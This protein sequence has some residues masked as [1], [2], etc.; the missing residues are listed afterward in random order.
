MQIQSGFEP[1]T[2]IAHV[3]NKKNLGFKWIWTPDLWTWVQNTTSRLS[4]LCLKKN[5]QIFNLSIN[6][7]RCIVGFFSAFWF[8]IIHFLPILTKFRHFPPFFT[9]IGPI[10]TIFGNFSFYITW[11]SEGVVNL[12]IWF[13]PHIA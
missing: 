8:Q 10:L 4:C 11:V 5:S 2:P 12:K 7:S 9:Y 6:Q 13:L 3:K 1:M